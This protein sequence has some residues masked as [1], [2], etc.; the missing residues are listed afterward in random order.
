MVFATKENNDTI[1]RVASETS[2]S[3]KQVLQA[4]NNERK[5][6]KTQGFK[7]ADLNL[8]VTTG[9]LSRQLDELNQS[10]QVYRDQKRCPPE[11]VDKLQEHASL[12]VCNPAMHCFAFTC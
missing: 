3:R 10:L 12:V 2:L 11:I 1:N 5:R 9:G 8:I 6:L 7:D 4:M